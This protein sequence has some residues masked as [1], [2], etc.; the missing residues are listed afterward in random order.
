MKKLS[1]LVVLGAAICALAPGAFAD[2]QAIDFSCILRYHPVC[3]DCFIIDAEDDDFTR[4]GG[5]G[6][7]DMEEMDL[8]SLILADPAAPH[9]DEIHS[10]FTTNAG[11][12][13]TSISPT[14]LTFTT[15]TATSG[16]TARQ[17]I[18]NTDPQIYYG[19]DA[20]MGA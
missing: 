13:R 9:H 11:L 15:P 4:Q 1:L 10:A 7:L 8:L 14:M 20:T 16:E 18:P 12:A 3:Y 6:I 17:P 2:A 5:L 19:A